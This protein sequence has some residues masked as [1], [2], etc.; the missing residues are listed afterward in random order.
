MSM[1]EPGPR[2]PFEILRDKSRNLCLIVTPVI[3]EHLVRPIGIEASSLP[4]SAADLWGCK[5]YTIADTSE[6]K[7]ANIIAKIEAAVNGLSAGL[8]VTPS[9]FRL[10]VDEEGYSYRLHGPRTPMIEEAVAKLKCCT[11][12]RLKV[13][14][15]SDASIDKDF[16]LQ[17][18]ALDL[19]EAISAIDHALAA[20]QRLGKCEFPD[21]RGIE[22]HILDQDDRIEIYGELMTTLRGRIPKI[23]GWKK[24]PTAGGFAPN[25]PIYTIPLTSA[26][27]LITAL[28]KLQLELC[29]R[30]RAYRAAGGAATDLEIEAYKS[31]D[32]PGI[33]GLV[34]SHHLLLIRSQYEAREFM[35]AL[36]ATWEPFGKRWTLPLLDNEGQ[37]RSVAWLSAAMSHIAEQLSD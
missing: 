23:K 20:R 5:A 33:I 34:R 16:V 31:G 32:I 25:Y 7:L 11:T 35:N 30:E 14:P 21:I 18:S 12:D 26:R 19:V 24:E 29:D 17:V 22:A 37:C 3:F 1:I 2:G 10:E 15:M 13:A 27:E 8:P 6:K 9:G 4:K 36:G 28:E